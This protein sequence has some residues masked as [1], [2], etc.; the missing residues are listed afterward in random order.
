MLEAPAPDAAEARVWA[1]DF[2]GRDQ[3]IEVRAGPHR[4]RKVVPLYA[5]FRQGD[6]CWFRLPARA[7]FLFDRRN[8]RAASKE[9]QPMTRDAA[10]RAATILILLG[11][12]DDVPALSRSSSTCSASR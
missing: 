7:V 9:P 8:G 12:G 5:S 10:Y 3:A 1:T 4:F 11:V 6:P 2:R